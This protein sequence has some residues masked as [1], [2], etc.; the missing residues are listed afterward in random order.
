MMEWHEPNPF[1]V[2]TRKRALI[3]YEKGSSYRESLKKNYQKRINRGVSK[4]IRVNG[5]RKGLAE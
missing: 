2:E 3:T 5:S 4:E 1:F